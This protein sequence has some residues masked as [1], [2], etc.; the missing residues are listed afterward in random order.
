LYAAIRKFQGAGSTKIHT[1]MD[2][3]FWMIKNRQFK[4]L[5]TA[6][7][8]LSDGED[9]SQL[10][11]AGYIKFLINKYNITDNFTIHTFGYGVHHC[12]VVLRA[13]SSLKMG[14][15]YYCDMISHIDR[16]IILSL[17]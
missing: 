2:N 11:V 9:D 4:N 6:V 3:A 12:P 1:G 8:L 7:Y 10:C 17:G 5:I 13:I 16:W 14:H 15:Y